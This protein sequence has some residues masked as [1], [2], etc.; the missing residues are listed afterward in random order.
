MSAGQHNN[1]SL[2]DFYRELALFK[3][4]Q[5]KSSKLASFGG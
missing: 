1:T 5:V 3:I 4:D 2:N